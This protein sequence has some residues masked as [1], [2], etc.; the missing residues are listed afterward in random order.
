MASE[1]LSAEGRR[2]RA[3]IAV[4]VRDNPDSPELPELRRQL[5]AD[6]HAGIHEAAR[7]ILANSTTPGQEAPREALESFAR[8]VADTMIERRTQEAGNAPGAG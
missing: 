8:A 6:R 1:Y 7:Q 2:I 5:E 4:T 3:K